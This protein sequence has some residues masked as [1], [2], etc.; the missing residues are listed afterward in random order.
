MPARWVDLLQRLEH[1]LD[2]ARDELSRAD[3]ECFMDAATRALIIRRTELAPLSVQH[4]LPFGE[5]VQARDPTGDSA[6]S[7]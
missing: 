7:R 4:P 6:P 2:Q 1:T 3:R 5:P